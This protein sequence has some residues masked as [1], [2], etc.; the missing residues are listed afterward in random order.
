MPL[1]HRTMWVVWILA[2]LELVASGLWCR[3]IR[4]LV[5]RLKLGPLL[6]EIYDSLGRRQR[7]TSRPHGLPVAVLSPYFHIRRAAR[8]T[9]K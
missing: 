8:I 6:S 2:S 7:R 1:A 9:G 4:M 5:T 3:M